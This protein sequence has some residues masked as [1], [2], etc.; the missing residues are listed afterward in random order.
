MIMKNKN[1]NKSGFNWL[2]VFVLLMMIGGML[3]FP[4]AQTALAA[5]E[6]TIDLP[7]GS[8]TN[9]A[10]TVKVLPNGNIL[11][12]DYRFDDGATTDVGAVHLY[13]GETLERINTLKG[14]TQNDYVGSGGVEIIQQG[15]NISYVVVSPYWSS[16][17]STLHVGAVTFCDGETG[18]PDDDDNDYSTITASN[19]LV[20]S[21]ADD[22]VGGKS[23]G[24]D[25]G[26]VVILSDGDYVVVSTE[27]GGGKGAVTW[28]SGTTGCQGVVSD[29]NSLIGTRTNDIVGYAGVTALD[30]GNYVVSS[31]RWHDASNQDVGA[32]TWCE[33]TA[34]DKCTGAV[35]A[36]NSLV[37]AKYSGI[38]IG[39]GGT[40]A[41]EGNQY[42]VVSPEAKVGSGT[43]KDG[44]VTFCDHDDETMSC[45]DEEFS[46]WDGSA[47]EHSLYGTQFEY[48]GA[49]VTEYSEDEHTASAYKSGVTVLSDGTYV[50]A[51]SAW[52]S[53]IES[54]WVYHHYGAVTWCDPNA[55][56]GDPGDCLGVQVGETNSLVGS[57]DEDQVGLGGVTE[58]DDG[59]YVVASPF[60]N[61]SAE[62]TATGAVTWCDPDAADSATG[63]CL[64]V[65]VSQTNSLVG[66]TADDFVGGIVATEFISAITALS[67]GKYVVSSPEWDNGETTEDAGA[68]VLCAADGACK[69]TV[70]SQTTKTVG[71]A[72][73]D[74]I[75]SE[76][77]TLV[78]DGNYVIGSGHTPGGNGEGA[79]TLCDP[80]AGAGDAN[81]CV[82]ITIS[83]G[84]SLVG[85]ISEDLLGLSVEAITDDLFVVFSPRWDNGVGQLNNG[86]VTLMNAENRCPIGEINAD[87]SF[88]GSSVSSDDDFLTTYVWDEDDARLL[89]GRPPDEAFSVFDV[90]YIAKQTGNWSDHETWCLGVPK[91]GFDVVIGDGKTVTVDAD[92]EA[93]KDLKFEIGGALTFESTSSLDSASA[94][95]IQAAGAKLS[96]TGDW[97]NSGTFNGGEG[98]VELTGSGEQVISSST[99][100]AFNNLIIGADSILSDTL[101]LKKLSA[102]GTI[103]N[104]GVVRKTMAL[105]PGDVYTFGITGATITNKED[106]E[107]SFTVDWLERNSPNPGENMETGR[108]WMITTTE[109]VAAD[110]VMTMNFTPSDGDLLCH[111][112]D[113][114]WVCDA[115]SVDAENKTITLEGIEDVNGIW[116]G[117]K[118]SGDNYEIILPFIF[119]NSTIQ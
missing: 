43:V 34:S 12:A 57:T 61:L 64:D 19:S 86:A 50:V 69:G 74:Q 52:G 15:D 82:D 113:S 91:E 99:D 13:D 76:G 4:T 41:L 58:L 95:L 70:A 38:Q 110:L 79:A 48:V 96:F 42:L 105:G 93:V 75:G 94:D 100:I 54:S 106:S 72:E 47:K 101:S 103:T 55:A 28:C 22:Y 104:S 83:S 45:Y 11:V 7:E 39:S 9:V 31:S 1:P 5:D 20:G 23:G 92:T 27:W 89:I 81:S 56:D 8:S 65:E 6:E 97:Q 25:Y 84:N 87:N 109:D 63:D 49:I 59:S 80:D 14:S 17:G 29:L 111:Y 60:W 117:Q 108:Y 98:T 35:A 112:V 51:S 107:Q 24:L 46:H 18:C 114:E 66:S 90:N 78:G 16:D 2:R 10:Y 21:E 67:D 53:V 62:S 44:A 102:T 119:K 85:T 3:Q 68:V 32:V 37:G 36:G 118:N 33:G 40:V 71:S 77:T 88:I 73:N 116:T 26:N 115:S 30:N